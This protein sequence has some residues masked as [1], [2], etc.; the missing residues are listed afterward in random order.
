MS[1]HPKVKRI[2]NT[3]ADLLMIY[4]IVAFGWLAYDVHQHPSNYAL[5]DHI[6]PESLPADAWEHMASS[7][8]DC[9]P[10]LN[11]LKLIKG[12]FMPIWLGALLIM[13]VKLSIS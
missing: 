5:V 4:S 13:A 11:A 9:L 8:K 12:L 10:A 1:K 3:L 6:L 2:V 7:S